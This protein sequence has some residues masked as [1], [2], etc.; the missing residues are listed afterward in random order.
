MSEE[1]SGE[2]GE[3]KLVELAIEWILAHSVNARNEPDKVTGD[4]NLLEE[5]LLDSLGFVDLLAHLEKL[6][7][8]EIDLMEVDEDDLSSLRGMCAVALNAAA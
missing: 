1:L 5:G 2:L 3:S 6:T 4:A 7:G 8:R